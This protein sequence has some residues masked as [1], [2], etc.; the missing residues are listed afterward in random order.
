MIFAA[1]Q[2]FK[3]VAGAYLFG[4][5][6]ALSPALQ[7]RGYGI[8]QFALDAV[9]YLVTIARARRPRPHAG[10]TRRPRACRKVFEHRTVALTAR[11]PDRRQSTAAVHG[12]RH[13]P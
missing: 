1:W 9:P 2:P 7:A 6:L 12:P 10:P 11:R 13:D 4:A 5:A 3:V 8:N